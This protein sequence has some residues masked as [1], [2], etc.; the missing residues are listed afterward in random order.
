MVAHETSETG[1]ADTKPAHR[2]ATCAAA[3][4]AEARARMMTKGFPVDRGH[5]V[6]PLFRIGGVG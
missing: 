1:G 5:G 3:H 6:G 2:T 4:C